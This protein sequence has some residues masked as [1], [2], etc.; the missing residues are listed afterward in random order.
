[1]NKLI[2]LSHELIKN[3]NCDAVAVGVLD[4][5]KNNF[6]FFEISESSLKENKSKIYFDLAS[7][8]KPLTNSL[9]NISEKISEPDLDLLLNHRAGIPAWGLLSNKSWKKQILSYPV[10]KSETLYSDFSALRYMLE[11]EQKLGRDYQSISFENLDPKI[12]FWKDLLIEDICVQN[13]FYNYQPNIGKVHDPNA[14][15]LSEFTSHAGLFGTIDGV[16]KTLLNF[17]HKY[18]LLELMQEKIENSDNRFVNGFDTV[19]NPENTLAGKG[20]SDKTFG[21]LGFTGTSFWIDA[22]RG[23]GHVILTNSTKL[24]WFDK[25]SLNAYRRQLGEIIW[26]KY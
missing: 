7:L 2:S 15:N 9:V 10:E 21:H 3:S 5:N 25:L 19:S 20:C 14:Y 26:Q 18:D 13:G 1:M 17:N 24:F 6:E 23:I 4:F 12:K 8:T 16:G 11:V 22:K